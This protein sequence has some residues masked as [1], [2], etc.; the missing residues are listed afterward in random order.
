MEPSSS[1]SGDDLL[2]N[3]IPIYSVGRSGADLYF[4]NRIFDISLLTH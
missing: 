1:G 3:I 2:K 4:G